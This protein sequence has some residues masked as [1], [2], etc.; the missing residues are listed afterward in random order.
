MGGARNDEALKQIH[1]LAAALKAPRL[2]KLRP[3]WQAKLETRDGPMR[4][5]SPRSWNAR[6]QHG[7]RRE[8]RSGSGPRGSQRGRCW[9]ASAVTS[10]P[11]SDRRS[12]RGRPARS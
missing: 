1:Y 11:P 12:A 7:T 6:S 3:G 9:R 2:R 4:T 10:S 5:T 8:L